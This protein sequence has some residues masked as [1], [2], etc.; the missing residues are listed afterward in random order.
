MTTFNRDGKYDGYVSNGLYSL[1]P[2]LLELPDIKCG[3][4]EEKFRKLI[5]DLLTDIHN[6][7]DPSKKMLYDDNVHLKNA[8]EVIQAMF[9]CFN[10]IIQKIK[11]ENITGN[12]IEV[13]ETNPEG[14]I[15]NISKSLNI[16]QQTFGLLGPEPIDNE[17]SV[18][19]SQTISTDSPRSS[20]YSPRS[21]SEISSLTNPS[22]SPRSSSNST[23]I[24]SFTRSR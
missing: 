13:P 3:E 24:S 14:S 10:C 21:S 12:C 1:I 18:S 17:T 8:R 7:N 11:D 9:A 4:I 23:N 16:L 20:S 19:E 5:E 6:I 15:A 22:F 2:T